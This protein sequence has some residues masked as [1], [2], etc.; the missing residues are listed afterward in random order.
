[1]IH[2]SANSLEATL[3]GGSG[4]A[5][6]SV[7]IKECAAWLG[8]FKPK[9]RCYFEDVGEGSQKGPPSIVK[10][11]KLELKVLLKHLKYA[12]LGKN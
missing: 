3:Q 7:E 1:M 12:Y 8:S 6:N 9:K 4:E 5:E 2:H 11:P 10:P